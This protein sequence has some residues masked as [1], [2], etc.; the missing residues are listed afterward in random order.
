MSREKKKKKK[1]APETPSKPATPESVGTSLRGL[2]REAQ[3]KLQAKGAA[4]PASAAS[5]PASQP[6]SQPA[7]K[8]ASQP[9][10]G[11][12]V[13]AKLPP[14]GRPS[15]GLRGDDRIA[16][17]DAMAGVRLLGTVRGARAPGRAGHGRDALRHR[18]RRRRGGARQAPRSIAQAC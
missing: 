18:A 15:D 11:K 13:K 8:P 12:D 4:A 17:H 16:F 9:V 3:L 1:G 10:R 14:T 5:K 6:A 2:L 7:S